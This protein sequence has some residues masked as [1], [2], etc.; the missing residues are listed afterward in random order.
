MQEQLADRIRMAR[1]GAGLSQSKA[2]QVLSVHR[3]TF[4]HWERGAGHQPT[5]ANLL[6]LALVM[7]VSYEWLATGRGSMQISSDEVAAVRLDCFAQSEDEEQLLLAFRKLPKHRRP[8]VVDFAHSLV[9][10]PFSQVTRLATD[11]SATASPHSM[12]SAPIKRASSA[13]G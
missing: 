11:A 7:G 12:L 13:G 8:S 10:H 6:Q 4:G 9:K 2:A 5:S 1:R 3:G